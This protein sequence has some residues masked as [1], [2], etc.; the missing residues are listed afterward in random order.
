M[1]P[2][3][4]HDKECLRLSLEILL[5]ILPAEIPTSAGTKT[6]GSVVP[7]LR[8][9]SSGRHGGLGPFRNTPNALSLGWNME[10]PIPPSLWLRMGWIYR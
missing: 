7:R 8:S 2:Y 9:T 10:N 5:S 3:L 1:L 4:A 6:N